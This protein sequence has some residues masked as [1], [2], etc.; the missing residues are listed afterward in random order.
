MLLKNNKLP[1][2]RI[3]NIK[4]VQADKNKKG[5]P[6]EIELQWGSKQWNNDQVSTWLSTYYNASLNN[7]N[8]EELGN[9]D[10]GSG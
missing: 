6:K 1:V 9:I 7:F 10:S 8:I 3:T 4:W 2:L 5:L